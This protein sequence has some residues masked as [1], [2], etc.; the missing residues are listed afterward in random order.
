M[1]EVILS[2]LLF[3]EQVYLCTLNSSHANPNS[4]ADDSSQIN[5]ILSY[6]F[7]IFLHDTNSFT[8]IEKKYF[9]IFFLFIASHKQNVV[10]S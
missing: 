7:N 9:Y 10:R 4:F 5:L 6:I 3:T 2:F 1:S 8:R